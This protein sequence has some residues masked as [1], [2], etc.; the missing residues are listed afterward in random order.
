MEGVGAEGLVAAFQ[1][2]DVALG[3]TLI[4][5]RHAGLLFP[6]TFSCSHLDIGSSCGGCRISKSKFEALV[7]GVEENATKFLDVLLL[8]GLGRGPVEALGQRLRRGVL[9]TRKLQIGEEALQLVRDAVVLAPVD[10]R[11]VPVRVDMLAHL[12]RHEK[13]LN[14]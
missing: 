13:S 6:F 8:E 9:V 5:L 14:Q 12:R 2:S 4:Q 10:L 3:D 11:V 1:A 7:D